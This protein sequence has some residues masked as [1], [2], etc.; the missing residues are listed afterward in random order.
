ML[1]DHIEFTMLEMRDYVTV[2]HGF[3]ASERV[4]IGL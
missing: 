2:E 1:V 4:I 3:L